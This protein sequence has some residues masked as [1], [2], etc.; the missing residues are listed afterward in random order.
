MARKQF[1]RPVSAS[2]GDTW[3]HRDGL[4][5]PCK[6]HPRPCPPG[7]ACVIGRVGSGLVESW[8]LLKRSPWE[9]Y[10]LWGSSTCL[11]IQ[12]PSTNFTGN[13]AFKKYSRQSMSQSSLGS[14]E[15]KS[16][17]TGAEQGFDVPTPSSHGNRAQWSRLGR[18]KLPRTQAPTF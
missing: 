2:L 3:T 13:Y 6:L 1:R 10:Y 8:A 17:H 11:R 12:L 16:I 9:I 5:E 7:P 15:Q 14:K 4:S 18:R